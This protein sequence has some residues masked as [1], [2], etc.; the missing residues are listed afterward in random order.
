[1]ATLALKSATAHLLFHSGRVEV[2]LGGDAGARSAVLRALAGLEADARVFAGGVEVTGRS[3][4]QRRVRYVP[5][6]GVVYPQ[7][8][9]LANLMLPRRGRN[10]RARALAAAERFGVGALLDRRAALLDRAAAQRVAFAKAA[11]VEPFAVLLD[12]PLDPFPA[13]ERAAVLAALR[14]A[15]VGEDRIFVLATARAEVAAMAGGKVHV[16][17]VREPQRFAPSPLPARR[18]D[19]IAKSV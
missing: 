18:P 1:M 9:V 17:G 11:A 13:E 10:A 14:A 7:L 5:S 8:T 3:P 15:F 2:L 19:G 6:G 16:L 4:A 12:E